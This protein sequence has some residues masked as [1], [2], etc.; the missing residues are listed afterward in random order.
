MT[1][2]EHAQKNLQCGKPY[3][4]NEQVSSINNCKEKMEN[5]KD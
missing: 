5:L 2:Q 3:R 4:T 1:P